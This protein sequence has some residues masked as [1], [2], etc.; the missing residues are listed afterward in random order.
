MSKNT[1]DCIIHLVG[2]DLN[3]DDILKPL[4]FQCNLNYKNFVIHCLTQ[5]KKKN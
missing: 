3:I 1:Y 5:K 2:N 4:L